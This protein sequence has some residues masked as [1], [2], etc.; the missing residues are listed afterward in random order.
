M[1]SPIVAFQ[2]PFAQ[3]KLWGIHSWQDFGSSQSNMDVNSISIN[4]VGWIQ[5][6]P[7]LV[8]LGFETLDKNIHFTVSFNHE[9]RDVNLHLTKNLVNNDKARIDL[10]KINKVELNEFAEPWFEAIIESSLDVLSDE[11]IEDNYNS[12][13]FDIKN[14]EN[15]ELFRNQ[16]EALL[17]ELKEVS[18]VKRKRLKI[19]G[20][21]EKK[22]ESLDDKEEFQNDFIDYLTTFENVL[23]VEPDKLQGGCLFLENE[24]VTVFRIEGRWYRLKKPEGILE[25]A[26]MALPE[27]LRLKISWYVR[28]SII[29]ISNSDSSHEIEAY[30][31]PIRLHVQK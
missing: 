21:L 30:S 6:K 29:R 10:L 16:E 2:A 18:R 14:Y 3:V 22:M 19:T 27:Q 23:K 11:F 12:S 17:A 25:L 15:S 31:N 28:R 1:D 26:K 7:H 8:S 5:V 20:D 9:S 13:Y 4:G 24:I